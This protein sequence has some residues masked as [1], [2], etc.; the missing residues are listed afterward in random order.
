MVGIKLIFMKNLKEYIIEGQNF[1]V[2]RK[3][4]N[5]QDKYEYHPEDKAELIDIIFNLL[6]KN[7]TDLNCID[8]S[9]IKNLSWV[10]FTV[11]NIFKNVITVK[12]I[13]VSEWD[14]SNAVNMEG[15]FKNCKDFNADLSK[16]DVSNVQNTNRMFYNCG[17]FDS[18]LSNWNISNIRN[19]EFMFHYSKLYN[20]NKTPKWYKDYIHN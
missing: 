14:V 1:L 18:D 13:D 12:D 9:K 6:K 10:F 15:M 4:N 16:W 11:E 2:N 20:E 19:M 8:V 5:R 7:I 17:K 3:L